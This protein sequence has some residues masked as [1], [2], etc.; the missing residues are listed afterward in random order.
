MYDVIRS[1]NYPRTPNSEPL[2]LRRHPS[3]RPRHC[4]E[5]QDVFDL[6]IYGQ[7]LTTDL[8]S[9]VT[10]WRRPRR[11]LIDDFAKHLHTLFFYA[12]CR[13]Q[14]AAFEALARVDGQILGGLFSENERLYLANRARR[15]K[16]NIHFQPP[17]RIA[18]AP[19]NNDL[20]SINRRQRLVA[21][22]QGEQLHTA[23]RLVPGFALLC[24]PK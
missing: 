24:R 23:R 7:L 16:S 2:D 18:S 22:L 21:A 17:R 8:G 1:P 20:N 15:F 9:R 4:R 12:V 10:S 14:P 3:D 5:H 11:F 6:Q 13:E 19:P